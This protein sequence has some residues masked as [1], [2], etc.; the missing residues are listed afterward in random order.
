MMDWINHT[1]PA[2]SVGDGAFPNIFAICF[3]LVAQ[4]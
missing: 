3:A 4:V 1:S 2:S